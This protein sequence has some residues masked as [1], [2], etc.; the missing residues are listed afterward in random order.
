MRIGPGRSGSAVGSPEQVTQ[1]LA[2]EQ[3]RPATSA[4]LGPVVDHVAALAEGR[5]VGG[6]VVAVGRGQDHA[7]P[8]RAP[9][10][11]V[12]RARRRRRHPTSGRRRDGSRFAR[13]VG[14]SLRSV[15]GRARTGSRRRAA[16]SR[17]VRR[18]GA[19]AGSAWCGSDVR[20]RS[21]T[22][23]EDGSPSQ[24]S[25]L[26]QRARHASTHMSRAPSAPSGETGVAFVKP[27]GV[28]PLAHGCDRPTTRADSQLI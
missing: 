5:E 1:R 17:S 19:G 12:R 3:G 27:S 2:S 10:V 16:P 22:V 28:R 13:A 4:M 7:G 20:A 14:R 18:S 24:G 26:G 11:R 23:D 21:V 6:V 25:V 8:A 9:V 15:R